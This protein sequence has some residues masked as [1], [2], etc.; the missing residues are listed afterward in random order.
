[1]MLGTAAHAVPVVYSGIDFGANSLADGV[2]SMAVAAAFDAASGPLNIIDFDTNTTGATFSPASQPVACG[3][4]LCDGNTTT[5]GSNYFGHVYATTITFD[6]P[7]DAF[8]AYFSGWQR[9]SQT[10]TY[11]DGS[12]VTLNMP[13][14]NLNLGGVVFFGFIDGGASI[15]SITYD[16]PLGD[17]VGID[18]V[19]FGKVSSV[20]EPATLTLLGFGFAA[21]GFAG[22][23]RKQ[24]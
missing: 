16:T 3:F 18:D 20:P 1:M 19:R 14:G 23:R 9:G 11:T 7:I 8:G 15:A 12:T 17:Y 10:L 4:A 24:A 13:D 22:R 21:L 6:A 5:G 2:N